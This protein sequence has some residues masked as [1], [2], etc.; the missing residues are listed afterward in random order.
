MK[1]IKLTEDNNKRLTQMD[2]IEQI[3]KRNKWKRVSAMDIYLVSW[4]LSIATQIS[5]LRRHRLM[6]IDN[7]LEQQPSWIKWSFY[8]LAK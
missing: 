5:Y 4:S 1:K 8:K 7:K 6:T 3:L 2:R